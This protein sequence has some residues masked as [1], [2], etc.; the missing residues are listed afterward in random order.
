LDIKKIE[1]KFYKKKN[2]EMIYWFSDSAVLFNTNTRKGKVVLELKKVE[3][4][5][6]KF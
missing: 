4:G 3:Q 2:S 6:T 1:N 5:K